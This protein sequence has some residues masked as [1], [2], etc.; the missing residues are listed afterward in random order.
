M[1][2]RAGN[3]IA[4]WGSWPEGLNELQGCLTR[5]GFQ[6]QR[7][8]SQEDVR[9]AVEAGRVDAIVTRLCSGCSGAVMRLL[10]WLQDIPSAPPVVLVT[11]ETNVPL[12]LEAMRRGAFDCVGLP[13]NDQELNRIVTRALIAQRL[14][15]AREEQNDQYPLPCLR[16]SL[17]TDRRRAGRT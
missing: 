15:S 14:L 12:Y 5:Q 7:V 16:A 10:A 17:F 2:S 11:D 8:D 3:R 6:V 4:V 9:A 13:L 1:S